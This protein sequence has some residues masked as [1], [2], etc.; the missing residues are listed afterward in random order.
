MGNRKFIKLSGEVV[1]LIAD[2]Q[3]MNM[4]N[5]EKEVGLSRHVGRRSSTGVLHD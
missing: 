5:V 3:V 2:V 4:L 1:N